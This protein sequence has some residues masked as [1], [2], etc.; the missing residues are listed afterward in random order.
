[1]EVGATNA[2]V[3]CDLVV[4]AF[5]FLSSWAE[6]RDSG[7][8]SSRQLHAT[9]EFVRLG[10]PQDIVDRYLRH[11]LDALRAHCA[12]IGAPPWPAPEWPG[13]HSFAMVLSHDVDFLPV[14]PL[15]NLTQGAKTVLR[16]ML[17]HR[18]PGDAWRAARGL[19]SAVARGRDPYGCVPQI[20]QREEALGVRSS[21]QVAVGHRHPNDV[22]YHIESDSVRDY[23]RAITDAG[24][25]LCLH[26]SYRSTENPQWY[27]EEV[28]LLARRLSR[29][30]GSRQHFLS[31]NYDTLFAAREQAGINTTCRWA[32]D[33]PG[34]RAVLLPYFRTTCAKT[35]L[36]RAA[37]R[38]FLMDVT[39]RGYL[40]LRPAAAKTVID[41]CLHELR[42]KRGCAS[43]VWHPIVFGGA[44]DPGYDS[45][46][47]EMTRQ[48]SSMGGLGTD[49][50]TVNTHYVKRPGTSF[51]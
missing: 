21:F 41:A 20:I 2:A 48:I 28:E 15:D 18:D 49:G 6:R 19:L 46:Y 30:Q 45:L 27:V 38:L 25:D 8:S 44:R 31:F 39:L 36:S 11:L 51:S 23:L 9:S 29:P 14:G 3:G 35:G 50:H 33:G 7:T 43:A 13:G 47:Y 17:R 22:N 16:H 32:A 34:P 5:Y 24:F 42:D 4:N 1:M 26:G 12:C 10:V 40:G 37:D